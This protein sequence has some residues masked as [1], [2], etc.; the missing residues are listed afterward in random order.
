MEIY[1]HETFLF[2]AYM[3]GR[4][5]LGITECGACTVTQ[6]T[7]THNAIFCYNIDSLFL[8][9]GHQLPFLLGNP[10]EP[11]YLVYDMCQY[12]WQSC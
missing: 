4:W 12:I 11:S 8:A 3:C 9:G 1:C 5:L 2:L 7:R 6:L 10:L